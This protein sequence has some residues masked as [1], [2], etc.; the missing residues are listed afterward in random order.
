MS[1]RRALDLPF[2]A[3]HIG[4]LLRPAD[5]LD[6]R[7]RHAAGEVSA[8]DLRAAED[9]AVVSAIALQERVGLKV[10]TDGEYRR[11]AYNDFFFEHL[12]DVTI[13]APPVD[14]EDARDGAKRAPQP[15]AILKSRLRWTAP[16]VSYTHLTLP[17][18]R[19]V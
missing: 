17:T 18:N 1:T 9:T 8:K 5:L 11:F 4:S 2:R 12:G 13:A 16:A 7:R 15:I 3:E 6:I 14:A 19:E 10:V